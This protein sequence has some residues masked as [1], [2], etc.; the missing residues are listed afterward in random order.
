MEFNIFFTKNSIGIIEIFL[1]ETA[2]KSPIC[3]YDENLY[4]V[5]SK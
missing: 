2:N 3:V 1:R 5:Y 4:S